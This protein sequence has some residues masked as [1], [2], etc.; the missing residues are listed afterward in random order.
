MV[1]EAA[2][3]VTLL[4]T[5]GNNNALIAGVILGLVFFLHLLLAWLY[6]KNI[7]NKIP[8]SQRDKIV[9]EIKI[10]KLEVSLLEKQNITQ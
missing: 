4:F 3:I 5:E 9:N 1:V 8:Y 6:L 10:L 2:T 7:L